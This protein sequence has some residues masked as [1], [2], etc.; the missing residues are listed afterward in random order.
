MRTPWIA[1]RT[2]P[3][4]RSGR[5]PRQNRRKRRVLAGVQLRLRIVADDG[6]DSEL[7]RD[8]AARVHISFPQACPRGPCAISRWQPSEPEGLHMGTCAVIE[9]MDAVDGVADEAVVLVCLQPLHRLASVWG[10]LRSAIGALVRASVTGVM[11]GVRAAETPVEAV[12]CARTGGSVAAVHPAVLE[13]AARLAGTGA[14]FG[15]SLLS[16]RGCDR[17][18]SFGWSR[19]Q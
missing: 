18:I 12:L 19:W 14:H 5:P 17:S 7:S 1:P 15:L 6:I 10:Q 16:G 11:I 8:D 9:T 4:P 13:H 3:D 2:A